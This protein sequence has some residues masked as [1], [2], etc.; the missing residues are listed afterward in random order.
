MADGYYSDNDY[1]ASYA[2]P[3]VHRLMIQD[4]A[5]TDAYRRAIDLKPDHVTALAIAQKARL[6]TQDDDRPQVLEHQ[7]GDGHSTINRIELGAFLKYLD[8]EERRRKTTR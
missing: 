1:F 4:H 2:D 5:R 6:Q 3:G 7:Q 8:D